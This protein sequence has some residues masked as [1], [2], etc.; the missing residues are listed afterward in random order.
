MTGVSASLSGT[1]GIGFECACSVELARAGDS[2]SFDCEP[3]YPDSDT[4]VMVFA[5]LPGVEVPQ[6]ARKAADTKAAIARAFENIFPI[7]T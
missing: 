2:A 1:L 6:P 7:I 4:P 5:L 3:G